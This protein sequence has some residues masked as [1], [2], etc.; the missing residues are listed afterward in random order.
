VAIVIS[1]EY[2][3]LHEIDELYNKNNRGFRA[4]DPALP[5][6]ILAWLARQRAGNYAANLSKMDFE[7]SIDQSPARVADLPCKGWNIRHALPQQQLS[8]HRSRNYNVQPYR[9]QAHVSQ[10]P[11]EKEAE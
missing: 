3:L 4:G 6:T 5:D 1:R 10:C 11:T 8:R 7:W 2:H 9:D